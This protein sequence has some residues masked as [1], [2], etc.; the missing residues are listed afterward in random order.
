M[1]NVVRECEHVWCGKR[2]RQETERERTKDTKRRREES[3]RE[4]VCAM[5]SVML[6]MSRLLACFD[7]W[8]FPIVQD[9]KNESQ[10][11]DYKQ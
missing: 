1:Y 10:T 7:N 3:D 5:R 8:V 2:E 9:T 6:S 4:S 11:S